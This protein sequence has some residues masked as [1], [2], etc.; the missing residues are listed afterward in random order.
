[1]RA[2]ASKIAGAAISFAAAAEDRAKS[3]AAWARSISQNP[4]PPGP[5][6]HPQFQRNPPRTAGTTAEPALTGVTELVILLT[7]C[8]SLSTS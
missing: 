7:L 5:A 3:S 8:L 1:M 4:P 6:R 2:G